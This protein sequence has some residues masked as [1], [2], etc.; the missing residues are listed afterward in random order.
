MHLPLRLLFLLLLRRRGHL[1]QFVFAL[2]LLQGYAGAQ[3]HHY[4]LIG[5]ISVEVQRRVHVAA[6]AAAEAAAAAA[7]KGARTAAEGGS[8]NNSSKS[9]ATGESLQWGTEDTWMQEASGAA[10]AATEQ[11]AAAPGRKR[12]QQ[13]QI[14]GIVP[15]IEQLVAF[16]ESYMTHR[17]TSQASR[18][19]SI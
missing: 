14:T 3:L 10:V 6:A 17:R 18:S 15:S 1:L 12:R 19:C 11:A 4:G 2:F 7:S 13:K 16:R 8:S 9:T 5:A